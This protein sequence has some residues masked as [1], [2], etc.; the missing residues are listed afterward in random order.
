M[1]RI[2]RFIATTLTIGTLAVTAAV[3]LP[4]VAAEGATRTLYV[5]PSGAGSCAKA[6]PCSLPK[7]L[8]KARSGNQI[9][10]RGGSY[11]SFD[12]SGFDNLTNLAKNVVVSPLTSK[13]PTFDE[14]DS[15]AP[16]VTWRKIRVTGVM[17]LSRGADYSV[18]D[19]AHLDG[20]GLFVRANHLVVKDSLFEGGDSIDGMQVGGVDHVLIT[21]NVVRNFNQ[22]SNTGLHADCVQIFDSSHVTLRANKLS[23]CYN[24]GIILSGGDDPHLDHLTIESNF[25]QGCIVISAACRGGSAADLRW[26]G[27][28]QLVVR[29]NTFSNGS[30]RLA[31]QPG[32]IFDR[33]IVGYLSDCDANL[34]NSVIEDWNRNMCKKPSA[35]GSSGNRT[36]KVSYV[37]RTG[38]DL[39]LKRATTAKISPKGSFVPAKKT[40]DGTATNPRRAGADT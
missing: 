26:V 31:D 7:A 32:R 17:F 4:A 16:H 34:T 20:T 29:N 27:A 25:V 22:N 18:V 5:S 14:L 35:A 40:I 12:L 15:R 36:G 2:L 1:K 30:V 10:L 39:H 3:V 9:K 37:D 33:N 19:R 38:G 28:K 6:S 8:A 24:A 23:N 11:G 13:V 21:R